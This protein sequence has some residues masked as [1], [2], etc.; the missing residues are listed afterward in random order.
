[1]KTL[2]CL[3]LITLLLPL[4]ISAQDYKT[5]PHGGK[6]K[7]AGSN[8]IE[9]LYSQGNFYTFLLDANSKPISNKGISC[10]LNLCFNTCEK[11]YRDIKPFSSDGFS[12]DNVIVQN[13]YSCT[14]L[15]VL[16]DGRKISAEFYNEEDNSTN[17]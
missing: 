2:R 13:F 4:S 3:L 1:M 7:N 10:S 5:G 8:K 15:F 11:E 14:I 12:A 16:P 9:L 17:E 6:V